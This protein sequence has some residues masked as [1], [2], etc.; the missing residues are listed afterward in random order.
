MNLIVFASFII[1]VL[2]LTVN[3]KKTEKTN[4]QIEEEFW[5]RETKANSVRKKSLDHLP[6]I[7][8]DFDALP[9]AD[10]FSESGAQVPESLEILQNLHD[11]KMLN[12]NGIS[13]TDLK[14]KYGAPNI[15]RLSEY[16][17]NFTIFSIHIVRL[18]QALYDIGRKSEAKTLL[19]KT[20]VTGTDISE[21]YLLLAR[22]Y[23]EEG[24][25][26]KI[27]DLILLAEK[28]PTMMKD[29]ILTRLKELL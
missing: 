18:A 27:N 10:S 11:K 1:F 26:G 19:E 3:L 2:W 7:T 9:T 22:L 16:E 28:L 6:Y 25:P 8:F 13:N 5:E 14:L 24:K 12:L 20:I 23:L 4:Q 29:T 17:E 15:T 21:H